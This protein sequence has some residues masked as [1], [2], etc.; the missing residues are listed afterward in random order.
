L[1]GLFWHTEVS[2]DIQKSLLTYR[3]LFWHTEVSF[4]IRKSLLTYRSLFW[5]TEV[6]FGIQK[7]LLTYISLF[8]FWF[9]K[10]YNIELHVRA[11]YYTP[12]TRTHAHTLLPA[13]SST[14]WWRPIGYLKLQIIFH[15]R[16]TI[17]RALLRKMTY[18]DKAFYASSPPC[19]LNGSR[20]N[21]SRHVWI[22]RVS[23]T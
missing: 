5:H 12:D 20:V 14:G 6:S 3:S 4:D 15:K 22:W 10:T 23:H 17:Y 13:Y 18:K 8:W 2:F 19:M 9:H 11:Q 1:R 21:E 7:S 16:A